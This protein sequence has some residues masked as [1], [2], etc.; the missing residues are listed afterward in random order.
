MTNSDAVSP[1]P[2]TCARVRVTRSLEKSFTKRH[3]VTQ[4]GLPE[5]AAF[6]G[7]FDL[8]AAPVRRPTTYEPLADAERDAREGWGSRVA[9]T[10]SREPAHGSREARASGS[11]GGARWRHTVG[12]PRLR[13]PD[14]PQRR[15]ERVPLQGSPLGSSGPNRIISACSGFEK[16]EL[17]LYS[18]PLADARRC[19]CAAVSIVRRDARRGRLLAEED[20]VQ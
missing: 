15:P 3:C 7:R 11:S 12:S 13:S 2:P 17:R 20:V 4:E 1:Y 9:R 5:A 18:A 8:D 16:T 19:P 10:G 6:A 14:A